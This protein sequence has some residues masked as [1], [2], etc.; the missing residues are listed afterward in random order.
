VVREGRLVDGDAT[1]LADA[2]A[3]DARPTRSARS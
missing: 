1:F 2:L 3:L